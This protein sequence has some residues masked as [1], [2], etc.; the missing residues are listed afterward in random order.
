[1]AHT[2]WANPFDTSTEGVLVKKKSLN[3]LLFAGVLYLTNT[4]NSSLNFNES[5]KFVPEFCEIAI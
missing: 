4:S 3:T 1:M 5:A 2:G